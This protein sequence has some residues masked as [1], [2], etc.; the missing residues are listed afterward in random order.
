MKFYVIL[1]F[2]LRQIQEKKPQKLF[3]Q[4]EK[5]EQSNLVVKKNVVK[6]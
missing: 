3:Y 4:K 1:Y 6:F 2:K 5:T